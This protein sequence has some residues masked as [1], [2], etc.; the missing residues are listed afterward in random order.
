MRDHSVTQDPLIHSDILQ[1]TDVDIVLQFS[2]VYYWSRKIYN[3]ECR[4]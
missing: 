2:A 1:N 3:S 4:S